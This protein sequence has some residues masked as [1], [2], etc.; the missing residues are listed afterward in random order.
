MILIP[1]K[2]LKLLNDFF[3]ELILGLLILSIYVIV[4]ISRTIMKLTDN[5]VNK[6]GYDKIIHFLCGTTAVA[7]T[8]KHG[9]VVMLIMTVIVF[10]ASI[11]KEYHKDD[12]IDWKDIGAGMLGCAIAFVVGLI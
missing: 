9:I 6:Y 11:W 4:S 3:E 2:M 7:L 1:L 8:A 12:Y 5:L 10:V